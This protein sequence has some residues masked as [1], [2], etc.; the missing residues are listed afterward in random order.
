MQVRILHA[1]QIYHMDEWD[2]CVVEKNIIQASKCS[3]NYRD[4]LHLQLKQLEV[5]PS[6]RT[7]VGNFR[8]ISA[9]RCNFLFVE[10]KIS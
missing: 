9:S 4:V 7:T 10:E 2:E 3:F 5:V 6:I 8:F 1:D